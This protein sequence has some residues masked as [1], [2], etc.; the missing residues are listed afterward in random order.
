[1]LEEVLTQIWP[2]QVSGQ[3]KEFLSQEVADQLVKGISGR[4]VEKEETFE[5]SKICREE[6]G[7]IISYDLTD[8]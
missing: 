3:Q 8:W 7:H 1:M 2:G 4:S 6:N 5:I